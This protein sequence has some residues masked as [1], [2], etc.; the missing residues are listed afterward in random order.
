MTGLILLRFTLAIIMFTH[1]FHRMNAGAV[2]DLGEFLNMNVFSPIG[3]LI[4]W[5]ITVYELLG[6]L[7]LA[8]G[9][10]VRPLSVGFIA[11]L[12]MGIMMI[13]FPNWFVVGAGENGMEYNVALIAGFLAVAFPNGS[14][15]K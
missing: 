9:W 5:S 10:L 8:A 11:M 14:G 15:K 7:M 12:S 3:V 13:H 4:A 1:S 2:G 6:S